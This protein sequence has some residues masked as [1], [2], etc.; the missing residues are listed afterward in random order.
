V[1]PNVSFAADVDKAMQDATDAVTIGKITP[2][3]WV[4]R[5]SEVSAKQKK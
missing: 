4:K 5:V 3:E 2:Q 1:V